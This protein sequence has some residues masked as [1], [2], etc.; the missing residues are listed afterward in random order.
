MGGAEDC[1]IDLG[2]PSGNL[3]WK[4]SLYQLISVIDERFRLKFA[5]E[6]EESI[7]RLIY[8]KLDH[9]LNEKNYFSDDYTTD[10]ISM[11]F[12]LRGELLSLNY[13][14]HR[15]DLPILCEMCN[16]GEREDI[17]HFIGRCPVLRETRRCIFGSDFLS[18]ERTRQYLDQI[19]VPILYQFC[20]IALTYRNKIL[21]ENF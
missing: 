11:M 4:A 5:T 7:Y 1:N 12:R 15:D 2:R 9:N 10:Q 20:K 17:F 16:M 14:P 21:N 8:S 19:N 13:I 3:S 18:E 6:A